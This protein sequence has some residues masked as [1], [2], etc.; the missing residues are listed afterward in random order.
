MKTFILFAS[1]FMTTVGIVNAA[2]GTAEE[3]CDEMEVK[4]KEKEPEHK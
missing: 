1:L 2:S 4:D 3:K